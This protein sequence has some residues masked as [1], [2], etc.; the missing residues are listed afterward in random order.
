MTVQ[1]QVLIYDCT[2]RDGTQG[3]N[4]SLSVHDKIRIA[5]KLDEFGKVGFRFRI[6]VDLVDYDVRSGAKGG[7]RGQGGDHSRRLRSAAC[8][9]QN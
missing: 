3:E 5:E 2:L 6:V 4:I 9:W 1:R 7:Y 8:L